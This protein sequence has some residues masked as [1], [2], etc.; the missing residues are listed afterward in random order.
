MVFTPSLPCG[1]GHAH[2]LLIHQYLP[3][4]EG[5]ILMLKI[6]RTSVLW[7]S[8]YFN[9]RLSLAPASFPI[10][11]HKRRQSRRQ[12]KARNTARAPNSPK[13]QQQ[14]GKRMSSDLIAIPPQHPIPVACG[15]SI[16]KCRC[17]TCTR[18]YLS[19]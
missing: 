10:C 9:P 14:A 12:E 13:T 16:S 2:P 15:V 11:C 5:I 18:T 8:P 3:P 19:N 4:E 6:R 1:E 7:E 17:H